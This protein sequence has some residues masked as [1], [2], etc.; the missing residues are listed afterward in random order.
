MLIDLIEMNYTI[1]N[2]GCGEDCLE[3]FMEML[4]TTLD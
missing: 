2:C 1:H 4:V 3:R